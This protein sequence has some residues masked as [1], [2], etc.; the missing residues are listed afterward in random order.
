MATVNGTAGN[1]FIHV[2]GD[3]LVAPGGYTDNPGATNGNDA[4]TPGTGSDYVY[5]GGGNDEID[6]SAGDLTS[7][8]TINGGSGYDTLYL[9]PT[10]YAATPLTLS[11]S[12]LSNVSHVESI[13][14]PQRY[15][16]ALTTINFTDAMVGSSDDS[17]RVTVYV[18]AQH[19]LDYEAHANIDASALVDPA[20]SIYVLVATNGQPFADFPDSM[21]IG[22]AGADVFQFDWSGAS[23]P[24]LDST[25]TVNGGT[26]ASLDTLIFAAG[27]TYPAS[28]FSGV[29][30]IEIITLQDT[31]AGISI[32]VPD[33]LV[34]SADDNHL[35]TINGGALVNTIDASL[36]T[37]AGN[38]LA[39]FGNGGADKITLASLNSG[40]T[41]DGGNDSATDTLVIAAA[42]TIAAADFA[43]VSHIE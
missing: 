20:N 35:L 40:D 42:A 18:Y 8:D 33:A 10:L 34:G 14:V 2:A 22:G 25:D 21:L 5:A 19:G 12:D 37:T 26:G 16:Y 17:H 15:H 4:I 13:I 43:N 38:E 3:G 41:V 32:A 23:A 36:V 6:L 11:A 39:I 9:L 29:S 7:A 24:I 31:S 1:D 30:H 27:G 28:S